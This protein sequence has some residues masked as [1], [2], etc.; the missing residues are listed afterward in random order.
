MDIDPEDLDGY[1]WDLVLSEGTITEPPTVGVLISSLFTD[2]ILLGVTDVD[3]GT[4]DMA[5]AV[6]SPTLSGHEVGDI[7]PLGEADFSAPPDFEIDG[8][9][10]ILY[11]PYDGVG[12]PFEDPFFVGEMSRDAA[13]LVAVE[14]TARLDTRETGPLFGLGSA[15]T[16]VC[17]LV[18]SLGVNCVDCAD[19]ET[20]CLDLAIDWTD[21]ELAPGLSLE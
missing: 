7:L 19:G 4:L 3:T 12:I 20:L 16:A 15:E 2:S 5:V 11:Y 14:F 10:Y 9:G 17:E 13:T 8:T 21:A 6:G 1:T 18:M